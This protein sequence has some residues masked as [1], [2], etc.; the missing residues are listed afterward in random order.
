[1]TNLS[2]M[3]LIHDTSNKSSAE[4]E[5]EDFQSNIADMA[6]VGYMSEDSNVLENFVFGHTAS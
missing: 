1:M 2:D 3:S 5:D 6:A 4:G